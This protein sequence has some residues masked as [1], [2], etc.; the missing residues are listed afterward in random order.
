VFVILYSLTSP[1]FPRH[2]LVVVICWSSSSAGRRHLLV[3]V[4]CWLSSAA[5]RRHLLVAVICWSPSSA[6]RRVVAGSSR[7]IVLEVY[8]KPVL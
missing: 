2:L 4:I 6:G 8:G 5:G 3:V 7:G 1:G